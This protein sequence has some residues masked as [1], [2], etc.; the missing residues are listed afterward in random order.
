[1]VKKSLKKLVNKVYFILSKIKQVFIN[2]CSIFPGKSFWSNFAEKFFSFFVSFKVYVVVLASFFRAYNLI[3]GETWAT[4][5]VSITLGRVVVQGV[6]AAK[7]AKE[8]D[9]LGEIVPPPE[10]RGE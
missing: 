5:V 3:G 2:A 7:K 8:P 4:V 10:H 6:V 9:E 1:M